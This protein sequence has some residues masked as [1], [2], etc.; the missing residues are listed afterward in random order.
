MKSQ[1]WLLVTLGVLL[2]T[3]A[4]AAQEFRATITGTV[5]DPQGAVIPKVRIEAKNLETGA[6]ITT[7]TNES[8]I[9]VLPFV[10]T[11]W[12]QLSASLEGFKRAV[13]DKVELRVGD[14]LRVDF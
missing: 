14:R 2:L 11:G 12:Y 1:R 9:Y 10:P 7:Q 13:R 4:S 8:G 3:G 6:V 5:T